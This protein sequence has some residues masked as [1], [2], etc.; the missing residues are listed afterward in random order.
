MGLYFNTP[1]AGTVSQMNFV[2]GQLKVF[3]C[4]FWWIEGRVIELKEWLLSVSSFE[5]S[6]KIVNRES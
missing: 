2:F 1:F 6:V 4:F 3:K 5:F